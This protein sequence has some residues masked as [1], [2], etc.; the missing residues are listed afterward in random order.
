MKTYFF[1]IT[2]DQNFCLHTSHFT[3]IEFVKVLKKER[4][5]YGTT[6][7]LVTLYIVQNKSIFSKIAFSTTLHIL[8][9][10]NRKGQQQLQTKTM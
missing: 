10:G 5:I 4:Y 2:G 1:I 3:Y 9:I 6:K 8:Y 7:N